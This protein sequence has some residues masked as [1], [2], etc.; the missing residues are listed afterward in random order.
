MP[1]PARHASRQRRPA[2][3][4]HFL[5]SLLGLTQYMIACNDPMPPEVFSATVF[6]K[7]RRTA[8]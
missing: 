6:T 2:Q 8:D 3:P 7:N 4:S 1:L 5:R